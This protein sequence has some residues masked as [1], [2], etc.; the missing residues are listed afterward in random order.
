MEAILT[1][2]GSVV[3]EVISW[4]GEMVTALL[5]SSGALNALFPLLALGIGISVVL[6]AVKVIRNMIWGA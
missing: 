6:L 5:G 1:Q 3:T 4:V 2:I